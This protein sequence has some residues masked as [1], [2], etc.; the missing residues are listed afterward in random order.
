[1][2]IRCTPEG[3]PQLWNVSVA[4]ARAYLEYW[5]AEQEAHAE[6]GEEIFIHSAVIAGIA[7]LGADLSWAEVEKY[8]DEERE[9]KD[10]IGWAIVLDP[11]GAIPLH[12]LVCASERLV[13][14][15]IGKITEDDLEI[16]G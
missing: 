10:E 5:F 13:G 15:D 3:R 1:M 7:M 8:L 16:I 11:R 14:F 12:S 9:A 6:E 2:K 4:D